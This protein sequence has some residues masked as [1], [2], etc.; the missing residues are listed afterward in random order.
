VGGDLALVEPLRW[1]GGWGTAA[2]I[3]LFLGMAAQGA[4][5]GGRGAEEE[6]STDRAARPE[7]IPD[8]QLDAE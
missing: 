2:A 4:L 3:L 7:E 8:L 6:S 5:T 1:W